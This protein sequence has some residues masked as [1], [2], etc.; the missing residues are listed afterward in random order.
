[1]AWPVSDV[2]LYYPKITDGGSQ[3][4]IVTG[5][6]RHSQKISA[7]KLHPWVAVKPDGI[8]VFGH[9]TCMAGFGE[10]CSHATALLF[11]IEVNN[12]V[13]QNTNCT[14]LT[15]MWLP[16]MQKVD[17]APIKDIDLTNPKKNKGLSVV[18]EILLSQ[19]QLLPR[20][21]SHLQLPAVPAVIATY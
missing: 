20:L 1:M 2:S 12:R 3:F 4:C 11:A 13:I 14:S 6:V 8:N 9:C 16:A 7:A 17:Y 21:Q 15:C 19:L 10:V 18:L 5:D